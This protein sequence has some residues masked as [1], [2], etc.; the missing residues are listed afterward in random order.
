MSETKE[1]RTGIQHSQFTLEE[2]GRVP[3]S[4]WLVTL[5]NMVSL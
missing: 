5:L 4:T 1:F 3:V 2:E